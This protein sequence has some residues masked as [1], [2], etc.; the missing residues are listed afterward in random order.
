M[1]S[2]FKEREDEVKININYECLNST[3]IYNDF[4]G[5]L[6]KNN[7]L[8]KFQLLKTSYPRIY[9]MIKL[10]EKG[11][12]YE[13][14]SNTISEFKFNF[15]F[16][17]L[18]SYVKDKSANDFEGNPYYKNY[19]NMF[20]NKLNRSKDMRIKEEN[21]L[22]VKTNEVIQK[23]KE[24][25][26][27]S[28]SNYH[29]NDSSTANKENED[30]EHVFLGKKRLNNQKTVMSTIS[31]DD[32]SISHIS[33]ISK[34]SST[35][36]KD[37]KNANNISLKLIADEN[38]IN[39]DK[40]N[41]EINKNSLLSTKKT[42]NIQKKNNSFW[43]IS[44]SELS[45]IHNLNNS[46]KSK[47]SI[48]DSK[49]EE[50]NLNNHFVN[51]KNEETIFTVKNN[52]IAPGISEDTK[53]EKKGNTEKSSL[54][55]RILF[56]VKKEDIK[57]DLNKLNTNKPV[58][59]LIKEPIQ[60]E[61][62]H[63]IEKTNKTNIKE[64]ETDI[65]QQQSKSSKSTSININKPKNRRRSNKKHLITSCKDDNKVKNISIIKEKEKEGEEVI[66]K[67]EKLINN[68]SNEKERCKKLFTLFKIPN[69]KV[70]NYEDKIIEIIDHSQVKDFKN[71]LDYKL[72]YK[73]NISKLNNDVNKTL[74][75]VVLITIN[76]ENKKTVELILDNKLN[77]KLQL[78][79]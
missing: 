52:T 17:N 40:I 48:K 18:I 26:Y 33:D 5:N 55:G 16:D 76:Q 41:T 49:E 65:L 36:G 70:E 15:N 27:K 72:K 25:N 58:N 60:L 20:F 29:K 79:K 53:N 7:K 10:L 69:F 71:I 75:N 22:I 43:E 13:D 8:D 44:S 14:F 66:K 54:S 62:L 11:K 57:I 6:F 31:N 3:N 42:R 24:D 12:S 47:T 38:N 2:K 34:R 28:N 64:E 23:D 78:S 45:S 9:D 39:N 1:E 73:Q 74:K 4:L 21:D 51:R 67:K 56:A 19:L 77:W 61:K 32:N 46:K 30:T 63:V 50:T 59:Y 35:E 68:S 37:K